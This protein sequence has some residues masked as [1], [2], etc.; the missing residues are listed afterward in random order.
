MSAGFVGLLKNVLQIVNTTDRELA[1]F[2]SIKQIDLQIHSFFWLFCV[3]TGH[4]NF[5][6]PVELNLKIPIG[7]RKQN[8]EKP[9]LVFSSR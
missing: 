3:L 8:Y 4:C 2:R 7:N 9:P 1:G 6:F 5:S